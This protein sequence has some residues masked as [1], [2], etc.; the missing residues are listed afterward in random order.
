MRPGDRVAAQGNHASHALADRY[1]Y[2]V[3][4]GAKSED[5]VFLVMSAIA[6]HGIRK[7]KVE[8]GETVAIVAMGVVGQLAMSLWHYASITWAEKGWKKWCSWALRSRLEPMRKVAKI[9]KE[10]LWG[11]INAIVLKVSNGPAE[12]LNSKIK[13]IKIRSRG[14][15]NKQRFANA[16]YFHLGGLKLYPE[17]VT[18]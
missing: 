6:M 17:G 4:D 1:V 2:R 3:P 11:I 10:H 8:L 15:R 5:A 7:A 18:R 12:G 9:I 14:F 13:M 16:I